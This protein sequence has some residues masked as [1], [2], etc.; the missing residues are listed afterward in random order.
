[1]SIPHELEQVTGV[2]FIVLIIVA[3]GLFLLLA[4]LFDSS[5]GRGR[6]YRRGYRVGYTETLGKERA[7]MRADLEREGK[8]RPGFRERLRK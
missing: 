7:K 3:I 1:M 8:K 6:R 2:S 5:Q 4:L